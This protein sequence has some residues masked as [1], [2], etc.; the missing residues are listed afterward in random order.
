MQEVIA[1]RYFMSQEAEMAAKWKMFEDYKELAARLSV[2]EREANSIGVVINNLAVA[3]MGS[4]QKIG[5]TREGFVSIPSGPGRQELNIS[6]VDVAG[7]TKLIQEI[8]ETAKQKGE[9]H[10]KLTQLGMSLP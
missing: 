9:L 5:I 1:E 3:L 8:Q 2:L 10:V 4:P 7:I 6:K